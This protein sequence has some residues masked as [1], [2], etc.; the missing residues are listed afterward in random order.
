MT[1]T[2]HTPAGIHQVHFRLHTDNVSLLVMN[3]SNQVLCALTAPDLAA[4][5]AAAF[6]AAP[7][8]LDLPGVLLAQ[9]ATPEPV[10]A[11]FN[12]TG[13]RHPSGYVLEDLPVNNPLEA[14]YIL[15]KRFEHSQARMDLEE[16]PEPYL[17]EIKARL[18]AEAKKSVD[19]PH[20]PGAR[21]EDPHLAGDLATV[22]EKLE[23]EQL[24][25]PEGE[26]IRGAQT[27]IKEALKFPNTGGSYRGRILNVLD[28]LR[29]EL[30]KPNQDQA[31][32]EAA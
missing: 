30:L 6:K 14:W 18:K 10:L 9:D 11:T 19:E 13:H 25:T 24:L 29:E 21:Q 16:I 5:L 2:L 12:Y 8:P 26:E 27:R 4:Q 32:G 7:N 17:A 28:A 23:V 22:K 1:A 20:Q 15:F 3:Q 31:K